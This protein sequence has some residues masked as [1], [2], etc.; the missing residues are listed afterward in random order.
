MLTPL[1][2]TCTVPAERVY[3]KAMCDHVVSATSDTARYVAQVKQKQR[4]GVPCTFQPV[5]ADPSPRK[6]V[7]LE[8]LVNDIAFAFSAVAYDM[9]VL[10]STLPTAFLFQNMTVR[11]LDGNELNGSANSALLP[12]N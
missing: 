4:Y 7:R 8:S 5:F 6:S 12:S 9:N 2:Y 11:S 10:S 1:T 3:T